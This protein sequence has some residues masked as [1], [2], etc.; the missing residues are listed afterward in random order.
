VDSGPDARGHKFGSAYGA[1]MQV[2]TSLA[3]VAGYFTAGSRDIALVAFDNHPDTG[4]CGM[5]GRHRPL[6]H[7]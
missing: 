5:D 7:T 4:A 2:A 6:A 3:V 1:F